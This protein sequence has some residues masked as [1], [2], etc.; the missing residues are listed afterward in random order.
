MSKTMLEINAYKDLTTTPLYGD[1]DSLIINNTAVSKISNIG[2][3]LGDIDDELIGGKIIKFVGLAPKTY[4]TE[5]IDYTCINNQHAVLSMTRCKGIP[6][7]SAPVNI[8][9]KWDDHQIKIDEIIDFKANPDMGA[10]LPIAACGLSG[11]VYAMKVNH[12]EYIYSPFI[13]ASEM[14]R[15]INK[16]I[17]IKVYYRSMKKTLRQNGNQTAI[18]ISSCLSERQIYATDWWKNNNKRNQPESLFSITT[19]VGFMK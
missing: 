15:I 5:Y 18:N 14:E 19:P 9:K 13:G 11:V 2:N 12:E 4:N 17:S 8:C 16:E 7:S 1:T 10:A 6:H 3:K